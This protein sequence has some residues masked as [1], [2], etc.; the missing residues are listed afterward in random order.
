MFC[1]WPTAEAHSTLLASSSGHEIVGPHIK[2]HNNQGCAAS[3]YPRPT[4]NYRNNRRQIPKDRRQILAI[5]LH[6]RCHR[7]LLNPPCHHFHN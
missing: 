1:S 2:Q 6:H 3:F 4:K 5:V 7:F